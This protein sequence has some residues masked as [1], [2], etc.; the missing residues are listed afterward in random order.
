MLFFGNILCNVLG[1]D[2]SNIFNSVLESVF[3]GNIVYLPKGGVEKHG[4]LG[5]SHGQGLGD[6]HPFCSSD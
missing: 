6:G 3:L 1:A 2:S 4:D 5:H